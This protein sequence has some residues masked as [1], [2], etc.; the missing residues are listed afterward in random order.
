MLMHFIISSDSLALI[1][2][3]QLIDQSVVYTKQ[4]KSENIMV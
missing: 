4:P 2:W 3:I 1:W